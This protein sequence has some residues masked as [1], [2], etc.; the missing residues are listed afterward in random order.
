MSRKQQIALLPGTWAKDRFSFG[1]S[2]L[3]GS[4]PKKARPFSRKLPIH[5]VLKSS[6]ATGRLSLLRHSSAI[7][8]LIASQADR[9]LIKVFAVSNAGNHLHLLIQAP[10]R[11]AFQGFIRGL[12]ARIS[13]LVMGK[14]KEQ[15][16]EKFE[17]AFWD[18]RPF[19]KIVSWGPQLRN[20]RRYLSLNSTESLPG[21]SR[22]FTRNVFQ[23][24]QEALRLGMMPRS[25][26]LVAAGF[27]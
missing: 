23:Q 24:I 9:R 12:S 18:A 25:D 21:M 2:L 27:S 26:S 11:E 19:S 3:K 8:R 17:S 6:R 1:G 7:A 10:T 22:G 14:A 16:R 20:V 5:I 13:Q 15:K 4:H